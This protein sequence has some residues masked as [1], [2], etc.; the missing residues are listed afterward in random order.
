MVRCAASNPTFLIET[1][2]GYRFG[3]LSLPLGHIADWLNFLASPHY[4][5]QIISAEQ[6]S[7][8]IDIFFEASEGLYAY[9]EEK[10]NPPHV[11]AA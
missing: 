4:N 1:V 3:K 8:H 11:L 9:I 5:A 6:D 7:A 2:D 10:L